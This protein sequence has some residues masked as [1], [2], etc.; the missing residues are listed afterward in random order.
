MTLTTSLGRVFNPIALQHL[1]LD[2]LSRAELIRALVWIDPQGA[3]T[4]E[5]S[6]AEGL[7]P[8]TRAEALFT[9]RQILERD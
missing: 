6:R 2:R 3:W 4:D 5:D 1:P 8:I 7:E 9:L